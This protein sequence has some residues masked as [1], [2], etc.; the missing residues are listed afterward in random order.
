[1]G[2][3]VLLQMEFA[4]LQAVCASLLQAAKDS[5]LAPAVRLANTEQARQRTSITSLTDSKIGTHCDHPG[6]TARAEK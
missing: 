2:R 6:E 4:Q 5:L 1:M 3:P